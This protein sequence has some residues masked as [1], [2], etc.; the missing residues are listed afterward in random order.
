MSLNEKLLLKSLKKGEIF[1][2]YEFFSD[3][4]SQYSA[5]V[6]KE[7]TILYIKKKDF[8]ELLKKYPI[9]NVKLI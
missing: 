6:T 2:E 5:W 7:T 1:C 9:D 4:H 8:L 3:L